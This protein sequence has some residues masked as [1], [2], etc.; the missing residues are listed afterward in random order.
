MHCHV[1]KQNH[2]FIFS[3]HFTVTFSG[4]DYK[5]VQFFKAEPVAC[6]NEKKT[7]SI[8]LYLAGDYSKSNFHLLDRPINLNANDENYSSFSRQS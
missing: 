4:I 8:Y 6:R 7:T 1:A 3:A 2:P 5:C